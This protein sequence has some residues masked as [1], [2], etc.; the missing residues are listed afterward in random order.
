MVRASQGTLADN[1]Q[2]SALVGTEPRQVGTLY[3]YLINKPEYLSPESR[4]ALVR[5]LR[6][7]LVESISILGV[8]RPI[9]SLISIV[10]VE[11]E[12]DKDYSFSRYSVCALSLDAY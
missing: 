9:E 10:Q 7:A 1:C 3:T 4:Q 5:R 2:V 11:R 6:E 12:E 8:V